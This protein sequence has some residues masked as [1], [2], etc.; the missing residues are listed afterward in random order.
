MGIE[1]R[2][3]RTGLKAILTERFQDHTEFIETI[4][5]NILNAD[6]VE[7]QVFQSPSMTEKRLFSIIAGMIP[8]F[9]GKR[10]V[11]LCNNWDELKFITDVLAELFP[12]LKIKL[13][14]SELVQKH[15]N[16]VNKKPWEGNA[17]QDDF[18]DYDILLCEPNS[19]LRLKWDFK[20]IITHLGAVCFHDVVPS[21]WYYHK[22]L[23][24]TLKLTSSARNFPVYFSST[25]GL[26]H[27]RCKKRIGTYELP[28]LRADVSWHNLIIPI[29]DWRSYDWYLKNS[30]MH[31][32]E[33]RSS[34][35]GNRAKVLI[36]PNMKKHENF[37]RLFSEEWDQVSDCIEVISPEESPKKF[38]KANIIMVEDI[39]LQPDWPPEAYDH[40][41]GRISNALQYLESGGKV[42]FFSPSGV[43][44]T[45]AVLSGL[46]PVKF[47]QAQREALIL[48]LLFHDCSLGK[49]L[50]DLIYSILDTSLIEIDLEEL[51]FLLKSLHEYRI[52]KKIRGRYACTHREKDTHAPDGRTIVRYQSLLEHKI[53]F[54][55]NEK[56]KDEIDSERTFNYFAIKAREI[57]KRLKYCPHIANLEDLLRDSLIFISEEDLDWCLENRLEDYTY[58]RSNFA[59]FNPEF[60]Q[61]DPRR[62]EREDSSEEMPKP[63][64]ASPYS[65]KKP[66]GR[67]GYKNRKN[68]E[69]L[70]R[71]VLQQVEILEKERNSP[72]HWETAIQILKIPRTTGYGITGELVEEKNLK[73]IERREEGKA[74]PSFLEPK[75]LDKNNRIRFRGRPN[76]CVVTKN[77]DHSLLKEKVCGKC[78][79]FTPTNQCE[80]IS[81]LIKIGI[82]ERVPHPGIRDLIH[83][84]GVDPNLRFHPRM[85]ACECFGTKK[86]DY[87]L[88]SLNTVT[89][90]KRNASMEMDEV[91]AYECRECDG[92][93]EYITH[94]RTH[95]CPKC[96]TKYTFFTHPDGT[97]VIKVNVDVHSAK[98]A[99]IR[100]MCG[101]IEEGE[102]EGDEPARRKKIMT[103]TKRYRKRMKLKKMKQKA[104]DRSRKKKTK[105]M[106][107][108]D[109]VLRRK[110]KEK[111]GT[112]KFYVKRMLAIFLSLIL[113]TCELKVFQIVEAWIIER[114]VF[115]QI[116]QIRKCFLK[117][118]KLEKEL[119]NEDDEEERGKINKRMIEN[120]RTA[121]RVITKQYWQVYGAIIESFG[122][123]LSN[124]K[125]L[126]YVSEFL[127][128]HFRGSKGY[129]PGNTLVNNVHKIC[130]EKDR[131]ALEKHGFGRECPGAEHAHPQFGLVLD[132]SDLKKVAYRFALIQAL[133]EKEI[134]EKDL[135]SIFGRHG[136]EIYLVKTKSYQKLV[137]IVERTDQKL[138]H[139]SRK[140]VPLGVA[141]E[142]FIA[143]LTFDLKFED[144]LQSVFIYAPNPEDYVHVTAILRE[145]DIDLPP[146]IPAPGFLPRR[147]SPD[148][149]E[150]ELLPEEIPGEWKDYQVKD[151]TPGLEAVH[152]IVKIIAR[153]TAFSSS[154]G[155]PVAYFFMG[156][157]PTGRVLIPFGIHHALDLKVG[158]YIEIGGASVSTRP[159]GRWVSHLPSGQMELLNAQV[160]GELH[161]NIGKLGS[162]RR[163][164]PP[165]EMEE[166]FQKREV[167]Q[168]V[169]SFFPLPSE[170]LW[171]ALVRAL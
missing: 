156:S 108:P 91:D 94:L 16:W 128:Q 50:V 154:Y 25:S 107:A 124:R 36:L 26:P 141:F 166:E 11:I 123:H 96:H 15:W 165:Q 63:R 23:G 92:V 28:A 134:T 97:A 111:Y 163:I 82:P 33:A 20:G 10:G 127:V 74:K 164:P 171:S 45:D 106:V 146:T 65:R 93:I 142:Y 84:K 71:A 170:P 149:I 160:T 75:Y 117:L 77:F 29:R 120:L 69:E 61:Y 19:F 21:R 78:R 31:H 119:L 38:E 49:E 87:N 153:S 131:D 143:Q 158:D 101:I 118:R 47:N 162:Y 7:V 137:Q 116:E 52:V 150:D 72:V 90:H 113:A 57:A 1:P 34:H 4:I 147:E 133:K 51:G 64:K 132:L 102:P 136:Q 9:H 98:N 155:E 13:V 17:P 81:E 44:G 54:Y 138:I 110:F 139:L 152:V 129:T 112:E 8:T 121:E 80:I 56:Y 5:E 53:Q 105:R 43:R 140:Q 157:D 46:F 59:R 167:L 3:N 86:R 2:L 6:N 42:I 109:D 30:I 79:F 114:F 125:L 99:V 41:F 148:F 22:I 48:F 122:F 73:E 135:Y 145:N 85:M 103:K 161:L 55:I 169:E 35:E 39:F 144:E 151:L 62:D 66:V 100:K 68:R 60:Q 58:S 126:R 89:I 32:L 76:K 159:E 14:D 115:I 70:K 88:K 67:R 130:Y 37:Y 168:L 27:I 83:D 18:E 40:L 24:F 12:G 95:E 104:K